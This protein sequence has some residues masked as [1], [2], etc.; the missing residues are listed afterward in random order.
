MNTTA[1]PTAEEKTEER[2]VEQTAEQAAAASPKPKKKR[3]PK[4]R[5][6]II[7]AAVAVVLVGAIIFGMVKFL[8]ADNSN[9][10][11]NEAVVQLGSITSTV[12]GSGTTKA[13]NTSSIILTS[14]TLAPLSSFANELNVEFKNQMEGVASI[15]VHRQL[16]AVA[17]PSYHNV[18]LLGS[19]K[20]RSNPLYMVRFRFISET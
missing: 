12:E 3:N 19:Y 16:F 9:V 7:T 20:N 15:D 2:M 17:V 4:R 6:Q 5:K 14:G 10:M 18:S 8:T 11:I 13:K 1:T